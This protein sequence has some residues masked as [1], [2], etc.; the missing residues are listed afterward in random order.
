M[1]FMD[2]RDL[3]NLSKKTVA[4]KVLCVYNIILTTLA[5]ILNG[6][7]KMKDR[8]YNYLQEKG[9]TTSSELVE[10]VLKIKNAGTDISERLME[11]AVEGDPR[12]VREGNGL[13][14]IIPVKKKR[15]AR[16]VSEEVF[17]V[18]SLKTT[19]P[20]TLPDRILEI[21]ACRIEQS[22]VVASFHSLV[23]PGVVLPPIFLS[24]LDIT[25]D[26]ESLP[27]TN[28]VVTALFDFAGDSV[29][30]GCG[31]RNILRRL[32]QVVGPSLRYELENPVLCLNL[33]GKRLFSDSKVNSLGQLASCLNI[34]YAEVHRARQEAELAA[35][36]TIRAV[37]ECKNNDI[38]TIDD[39]LEFQYPKIDMVD[40]NQY[41]F[42]REFLRNLPER[43]GIYKMRDREDKVVYI[44][45]AKNLNNRISSYFRSTS[46]RPE[47]IATVLQ[48]VYS[49][50]YEI[51]GSELEALLY[52]SRSIR[53]HKPDINVQIEVH[54]RKVVLKKE[55]NVILVLPSKYEDRAELVLLRKAKPLCQLS[56][57]RE[58]SDLF[59][60]KQAIE[61]IYFAKE[62]VLATLSEEERA[63]IE[64]ATS[65]FIQ[66]R[67]RINY[68]DMDTVADPDDA[69]RLVI[70]YMKE[71]YSG[72]K[73]RHI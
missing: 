64:I 16:S 8:I 20:W 57:E 34:V 28:E 61:A 10:K 53:E 39:L 58:A 12:L 17:T 55:R 41:I 40:F 14:K 18:L 37:E 4:G 27:K 22:K 42:D 1:N 70:E 43:P 5:G 26:L 25:E 3:I 48:R 2:N 29:L 50:E 73:V 31:I 63:D 56:V 45:K 7:G 32:E 69:V 13:W 54:D 23:D 15:I 46:D 62:E 72:N 60:V 67:D 68:L 38:N 9:A 35:E 65:W 59:E 33:L 47:K 51:L 49:I 6:N 71:L 66:N 11:S 21:G 44:G 24:S 36:I 52:E 19:A 30:V